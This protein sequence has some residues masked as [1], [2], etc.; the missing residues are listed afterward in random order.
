[1][2]DELAN[3]FLRDGDDNEKMKKKRK[4]RGENPTSNINRYLKQ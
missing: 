1:M 4:E 3:S 2:I